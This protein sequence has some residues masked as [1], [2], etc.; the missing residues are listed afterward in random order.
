FTNNENNAIRLYGAG[1][2]P[3]EF[4]KDGFHQHVIHGEA[5]VDPAQRGTKSCIWYERSLAAGESW[6]LRLRL[7]P[8]ELENPLAAVDSTVGT[9][10]GEAD[11]FYETVHP[12]KA[13][14]EERR[15][16]RQAL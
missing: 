14:A 5:S 8:Q 11:E 13:N 2:N 10:R 7:S 15:I 4:V 9:R 1:N 16:Q 12:P 6:T 3:K